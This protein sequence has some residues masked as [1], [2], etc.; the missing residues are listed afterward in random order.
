MVGL[1]SL[2]F[3]LFPYTGIFLSMVVD[4]YEPP[5]EQLGYS[6]AKITRQLFQKMKECKSS[7]MS[8]INRNSKTGIYQF[9]P[10]NLSLQSENVEIPD[11]ND[12]SQLSAFRTVLCLTVWNLY[13]AAPKLD[14]IHSVYK[15]I[16]NGF[17]HAKLNGHGS[18]GTK[19]EMS[20]FSLL[21]L[22]PP[23]VGNHAYLEK[24]LVGV[25]K[26][27]FPSPPSYNIWDTSG[28]A[29]RSLMSSISRNLKINGCEGNWSCAMVENLLCKFVRSNLS[30]NFSDSHFS[31]VHR[32]NQIVII[33]SEDMK[34]LTIYSSNHMVECEEGVIFHQWASDGKPVSAQQLGELLGSR[35]RS[36]QDDHDIFPKE[37][38]FSRFLSTQAF[39]RMLEKMNHPGNAQVLSE[40]RFSGFPFP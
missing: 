39:Q 11:V 2:C 35:L 8:Q 26:H 25:L 40:N 21:G 12:I 13:P 15:S 37:T 14:K 9:S 19:H 28:K 29:H 31:D 17:L 1:V 34:R 23:W 4:T 32:K 16:A 10:R 36:Q 18:L 7:F 22:L 38:S 33:S 30:R 27:H 5:S 24:N 20:I 3:E 6:A